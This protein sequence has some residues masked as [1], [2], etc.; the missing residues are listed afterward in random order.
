MRIT[1]QTESALICARESRPHSLSLQ[2][3]CSRH[4]RERRAFSDGQALKIHTVQ[5]VVQTD[6]HRGSLLATVKTRYRLSSRLSRVS[7]DFSRCL[8]PVSTSILV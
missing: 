5:G 1:T 3:R 2:F 4:H 6:H 7:S 8:P